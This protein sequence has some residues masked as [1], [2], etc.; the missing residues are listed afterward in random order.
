M[1]LSAHANTHVWICSLLHWVMHPLQVICIHVCSHLLST[2]KILNADFDANAILQLGVHERS[3]SE[4]Q[5][6]A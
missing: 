4:L 2:V 1:L 5:H 6:V 3:G